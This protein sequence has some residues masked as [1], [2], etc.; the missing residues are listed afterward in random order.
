MRRC[1]RCQCLITQLF[2]HTHDDLGREY[3]TIACLEATEKYE[4][5]QAKRC[6]KPWR[7]PVIGVTQ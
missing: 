3:C 7:K 4:R 1:T 6:K 2:S 5:Y